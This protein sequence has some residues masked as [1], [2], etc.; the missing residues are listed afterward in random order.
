MENKKYFAVNTLAPKD[1]GATVFVKKVVGKKSDGFAVVDHG[2]VFVIDVGKADDVELIDYLLSLREAWIGEND[3][4]ED[5]PARLE[6]VIIVSHPHSDHIAAL[7]LL[8]A[9]ERFCVTK[10]YAPMRSQISFD[11]E[12]AP[13]SLVTCENRLEDF[14]ELLALH[15]H[16]AKGVTRIPFGKVYP[17]E[18]GSEDLTMEI[19]P[20]H[21]DWSEDLP[22]DK[23][24]YRYIL[25]NN[26][27][28]YKEKG[29]DPEKGYCNGVL[30][31]NSLW[32]KVRKGENTVL[33]TGDQRDRDEMMGEMLRYYGEETF[34]CDVLKLAHHGEENYSPHLLRVADPKFAVFTTSPDKVL[35]ETLELYEEY[36]C[37]NYYTA[38]GNLFFYVTEK[39]IKPYGIEPR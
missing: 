24:G 39:E 19:Y 27:A 21:I 22:S 11:E 1:E 31:G 38:D 20:S 29:L 3:L 25:A 34:K 6:I 18:T 36:G 32:V 10:M 26:P 13:P 4:P 37:A 16:T 12:K 8:L 28:S 5:M 17:V 33:I 30:N 35:P 14:C 7:P 9:D 15:G 23:A 2:K